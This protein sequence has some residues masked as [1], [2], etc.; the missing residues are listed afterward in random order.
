MALAET[1]VHG[2]A[3]RRARLAGDALAMIADPAQLAQLRLVLRAIDSRAVN[4]VLAASPTAVHRDV[5]GRPPERT[6]WAGP[7][8]GCPQRRSAFGAFRK[9]DDVPGLR[10]SRRRTSR[11]RISTPVGY[12]PDDPPVTDHPTSI[13]PLVLPVATGTDLTREV[14]L[15]ADAVV[16]GS[17]AGGGVSRRRSRLRAARRGAS[18][19]GHSQTR[20]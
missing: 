16:V 6:S 14:T 12:R 15:Q 9:A 17:G 4:L 2:D 3:E 11:I 1:F 20:G 13:R 7:A 19:P 18:K 8:P 10:R 5:A